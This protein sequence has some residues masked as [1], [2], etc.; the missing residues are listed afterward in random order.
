[1]YGKCSAQQKQPFLQMLTNCFFFLTFLSTPILDYSA[2]SSFGKCASPPSQFFATLPPPPGFRD[3]SFEEPWSFKSGENVSFIQPQ[4]ITLR[5]EGRRP[6]LSLQLNNSLSPRRTGGGSVPCSPRSPD[7]GWWEDS[8]TRRRGSAGSQVSDPE[9][10]EKIRK[11]A[12]TVQT[13]ICSPLQE[14]V[15]LPGTVEVATQ[16][17]KLR[18]P[19]KVSI[20]T[21]L[22]D[23]NVSRSSS[24]DLPQHVL[25]ERD[26]GILKRLPAQSSSESVTLTDAA[27]LRLDRNVFLTT[28]EDT[29]AAVFEAQRR[30]LIHRL[31][32]PSHTSK[33][34][35][36]QSSTET[37]SDC[38]SDRFMDF[39]M[40]TSTLIQSIDSR[41]SSTE[42]TSEASTDIFPRSES[43]DTRSRTASLESQSSADS[44]SPRESKSDSCT[45]MPVGESIEE[46][47]AAEAEEMGRRKPSPLPPEVIAT[48][49][50]LML[51]SKMSDDTLQH[52]GMSDATS[53]NSSN[54]KKGTI[55][56]DGELE[57]DTTLDTTTIEEKTVVSIPGAASGDDDGT[58]K[59]NGRKLLIKA[60]SWDLIS[61]NLSEE[62]S[63]LIASLGENICTKSLDLGKSH[64]VEE[65]DENETEQGKV[66][67]DLLTVQ[68]D[69]TSLSPKLS[70][71][72]KSATTEIAR[73]VCQ[74][75]MKDTK[76]MPV[77]VRDTCSQDEGSSNDSSLSSGYSDIAISHSPLR[78][79]QIS[80]ADVATQ[81]DESSVSNK[82]LRH[83]P[84]STPSGAAPDVTDASLQ[85][86]E[87]ETLDDLASLKSDEVASLPSEG[88]R[89][90][91]PIEEENEVDSDDDPEPQIGMRDGAA[92]TDRLPTYTTEPT[93]TDV[94]EL[95][96]VYIHANIVQR[97]KEDDEEDATD[98]LVLAEVATGAPAGVVI[99]GSSSSTR[100]LKVVEV[101]RKLS[102]SE[103]I[104]EL[105]VKIGAKGHLSPSHFNGGLS[106]CEF[107]DVSGAG[108][109]KENNTLLERSESTCVDT[110]F[111][112]WMESSENDRPAPSAPPLPELSP[113]PEPHPIGDPGWKELS[114]AFKYAYLGIVPNS[115]GEEGPEGES[116]TKRKRLIED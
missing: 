82:A 66:K 98:T 83:R 53:E 41:Q 42:V 22:V 75:P 25:V 20:S 43:S 74:K 1:M 9:W 62:L 28:D 32:V 58:D 48:L 70:G 68:D 10:R 47:E 34:D 13:S 86:D 69:K 80:G 15:P 100:T 6:S 111:A 65:P 113:P 89:T 99:S 7:E 37:T 5:H 12:A 81:T 45:L 31:Q 91:V 55:D 97:S 104:K 3:N 93:L 71:D 107:V 106:D 2:S 84:R 8:D 29:D 30:L 101:V 56:D 61:E 57:E 103:G 92:S 63:Q 109:K 108:S 36:R 102:A 33:T 77:E 19:V 52:L 78:E 11:F 51:G 94:T 35:S 18:P 76:E 27:V 4:R 95:P 17:K 49:R 26:G 44:V 115:N 50:A 46:E 54:D 21:E 59:G 105:K 96:S 110:Q 88:A 72:E 73:S 40:G 85:T 39:A 112:S 23:D 60:D 87:S 67:L 64:S 116:K 114:S 16:Q 90:P 38:L 14:S 24:L 79:A